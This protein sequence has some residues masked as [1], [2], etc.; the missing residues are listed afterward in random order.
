MTGQRCH[1]DCVEQPLSR[2]MRALGACV[3]SHPWPFFLVPMA[4]AASL[5]AGFMRLKVLE[6]NDIEE[7]FTP[8][9]GPAKSERSLVRM[10]FPTD[11]SERFSA[12]RLTTEGSFAVLIAVGND[13]ILTREAFAELLALDKAVRA[14][15]SETGLFFEEVCA[16]IGPAGPC[17]S[18]NPLLSAMQGD[19]ARIEALL[20]SLTFPLFMGRVPLGFFLGGVTLDAGVPPAR[21]V[22][23]AKALRLLYFL[24]EDHAGPKEESQRWIHTFLQRAPQLLRSLNLTSIRVAYFTSVSRQEEFEK[25]S[26]DVIPFVSITYF[27]TIFF[28]IISCSRLDCVRTKVWV[29]AFGVVSVG[30]SVLSSFGLLM[31]CGVPFVITAAN[32]PFLILGVGVDDMF[33]LVSCWQHTKVKSSIKDRMADTYEEAAVSVTITTVTD[34]LAFYIG[35]GSSFQS[36]QS[37]CIYT[38]T[39]FVF[40]YIYNLTFLGAV[41][42]LNGRREEGNKHWL[43]FMKVS[44]EPQDSQLYNICCVGGSFDETTGTEFEHPMNEFFRKYY[45]PFLMLTWTKIVV[46]LLYLMYMGCSIYG[47]TQVREGINVR[48]LA[49][50]NSYVV[51]Y[52]DWLD[53]YFSEYGPR[54]M[55]VVSESVEYWDPS[56][57]TEIEKCM[58]VFER[59]SDID[60]TL[61]ESWL[62]NYESL[63]KLTSININ[64][65]TI[66]IDKLVD[67]YAA[68]PDSEWD[69]NSSTTEIFAS[70]F[71]IQAV[72]ITDAVHE[73]HFLNEL[74]N[75]AANCKIPLMVYHPAFIY[76]DQYLVIIPNTIQN[77]LIATAVM[78]I[79]SLTFIPNPLCSLWVTF[80]IA[81]VIVGVTGFMTLWGVNLDSI[82]MINLVICIGFSVDFSAHIS[83]AFVASEEPNVND[84]A[85]NAVYML[86]YPILQGAGSTLLGV[87]VL[88]MA[89]SYIFRTF[90]KIMSLVIIFGAMHGI[91]FIPVFLTFFGFCAGL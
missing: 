1:T 50:D 32:S 84:K 5:G 68:S 58:E 25:I 53:E 63:S 41:L 39:A 91:L 54:V 16:K 19:P 51:Q 35:I 81:S 82:S 15:R 60:K 4:L 47:C 24:Q 78:L 40:C 86:G 64:D 74:R 10:H 76:L 80:A 56:I 77:V 2:A 7:Q 62:R 12:R 34:V 83:Y 46:V 11:D 23:A 20:P 38:G 48:N 89:R 73:K 31:F 42:A 18:P 6:A 22:R 8:I 85:R 55:V 87:L 37:F 33:I 65:R 57:R 66:F 45:A 71:F 88:C 29:A 30:L 90:F 67:L 17:N 79:V 49:I 69:I 13:S 9:G 70:R 52:Y 72:N 43:T 14:L 75:L 26:K 59:S 44:R 61:S 21:P 28:A 3:G 36:V 27:L